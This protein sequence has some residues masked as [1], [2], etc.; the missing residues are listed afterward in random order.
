MS[1]R[2]KRGTK[3]SELVFQR[4]TLSGDIVCKSCGRETNKK[5]AV[6]VLRGSGRASYKVAAKEYGQIRGVVWEQHDF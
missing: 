4:L 3:V 2:V 5:A 1:G 6:L